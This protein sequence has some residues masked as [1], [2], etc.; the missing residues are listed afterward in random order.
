MIQYC[1]SPSITTD[2]ESSTNPYPY[3]T[4]WTIQDA[5]AFDTC[6]RTNK[7]NPD[8]GGIGVSECSNT[9]KRI[10]LTVHLGHCCILHRTVFALV[11]VG[12][13]RDQIDNRLAL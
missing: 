6:S 2:D 8:L 10:G 4:N 11:I 13:V 3:Y 1:C 9:F 5:C 7:G 12:L